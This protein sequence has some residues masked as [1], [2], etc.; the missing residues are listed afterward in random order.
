MGLSQFHRM[1][2]S[3]RSLV[4]AFWKHIQ[5]ILVSKMNI[6]N[7][8]SLFFVERWSAMYAFPSS[9][10]FNIFLKYGSSLSGYFLNVQKGSLYFIVF[11]IT[12]LWCAHL[13]SSQMLI[14]KTN[15]K[16]PIFWKLWGCLMRIYRAIISPVWLPKN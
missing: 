3:C 5:N 9:F 2:E 15:S 4:T 11:L 16:S 12:E 10:S 14:S 8:F 13:P 1:S 7:F 6:S